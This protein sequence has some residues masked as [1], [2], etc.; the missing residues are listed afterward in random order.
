MCR[1]VAS[2]RLGHASTMAAKSGSKGS[3]SLPTAPDS[4][5]LFGEPPYF[6]RNPGYVRVPSHPLSRS[7]PFYLTRSNINPLSSGG[8]PAATNWNWSAPPDLTWAAIVPWSLLSRRIALPAVVIVPFKLTVGL[9]FGV[10]F[11]VNWLFS[12]IESVEHVAVALGPPTADQI[13]RRPGLG[14]WRLSR[15]ICRGRRGRRFGRRRQCCEHATG[16]LVAG[17]R[18]N[19]LFQLLGRC[20]AMSRN[21]IV[22]GQ[23]EMGRGV[24]GLLLAERLKRP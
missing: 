17:L 4:A 6:P 12:S 18:G 8:L 7:Y 14:R 16:H 10:A 9:P 20:I 24:V 21:Q 13:G 1:R 5:A 15:L 11:Q 22:I 3:F 23:H 2:S 19:D